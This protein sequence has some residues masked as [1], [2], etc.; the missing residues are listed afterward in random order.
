MPRLS[1]P[2]TRCPECGSSTLIVR[3][4]E[5]GF[6]TQ[7]CVKECSKPRKLPKKDLPSLICGTCHLPLKPV[8]NG[9]KNYAY[10]CIRCGGQWELASLVPSWA[11]RF[12]YD[13]LAL[14]TDPDQ[15]APYSCGGT[16]RRRNS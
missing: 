11:E 2:G 1:L 7:N 3:S 6:V 16:E 15:G 13:G 12:N 9:Q 14:D 8:I 5:G 10:Q 4:R